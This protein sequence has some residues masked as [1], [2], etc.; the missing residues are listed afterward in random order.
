MDGATHISDPARIRALAHPLRLELLD[1]LRDAGE[2]TATECAAQV[3]ESVASC[4][5]HLRM[6]AKY[7]FLE[8]AERRGKEKP[9]RIAREAA[10]LNS[11]PDPDVPSLLRLASDG[12]PGRFSLRQLGSG[13][14]GTEREVHGALFDADV[15][16]PVVLPALCA[17]DT[18]R[19]P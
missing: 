17:G 8:R 6:L 9:W 5:F 10:N 16:G 12:R 3:G 4:S 7:G 13:P 15:F 18:L 14:H 1:H 19:W 2:A 11:R